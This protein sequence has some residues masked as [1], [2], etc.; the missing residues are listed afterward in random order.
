[1]RESMSLRGDAHDGTPGGLSLPQSFTKIKAIR[2]DTQWIHL[3]DRLSQSKI[4]LFRRDFE[5]R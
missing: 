5:S 4:E 3:G 1:M 2:D